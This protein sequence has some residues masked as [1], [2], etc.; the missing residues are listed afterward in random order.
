MMP[1]WFCAERSELAKKACRSCGRLGE[2]APVGGHGLILHLAA[3][4]MLQRHVEEDPLHHVERGIGGGL[5]ARERERECLRIVGEGARGAAEDVARELVEQDHEAQAP[6]R[7]VG[8]AGKPACG[9]LV[10]QPAEAP[11][12]GGIA[13]VALLGRGGSE[14]EAHAPLELL[15]GQR[16]L[17]E[18]VVPH[19]ARLV[20]LLHLGGAVRIEQLLQLLRRLARGRQELH[21]V[22]LDRVLRQERAL[23]V[24][25]EAAHH[26]ARIRG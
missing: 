26:L 3:L 18:P 13:M 6:A 17:T 14:P 20:H 16:Q 24:L 1:R 21:L 10:E 9:R 22:F 5:H 7:P 11:G 4:G 19:A 2:H 12:D 25:A 23:V 8:P 15:G